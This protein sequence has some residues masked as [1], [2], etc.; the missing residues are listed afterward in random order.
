MNICLKP[1]NFNEQQANKEKIWKKY[2]TNATKENPLSEN[3]VSGIFMSLKVH[4]SIYE[5]KNSKEFIFMFMG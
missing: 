1:L 4:Y 2:W 5:R 3:N